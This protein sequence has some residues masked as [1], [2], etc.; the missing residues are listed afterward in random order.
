[1]Y[2]L[3]L[4]PRSWWSSNDLNRVFNLIILGCRRHPVSIFFLKIIGKT[5]NFIASSDLK[6]SITQREKEGEV[7]LSCHVSPDVSWRQPDVVIEIDGD[8]TS[9]SAVKPAHHTLVDRLMKRPT[10]E[11]FINVWSESVKVWPLISSTILL[12]ARL[13]WWLPSVP[14]PLLPLQV[15]AQRIPCYP[16]GVHGHKK[17]F[18]RPM[19]TCSRRPWKSWPP[20]TRK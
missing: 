2:V 12:S 10:V 4:I 6:R 3:R 1:M 20:F 5:L 9:P 17:Y 18:L 13:Y 11:E 7:L 8:V 16:K 19:L 14:I 15:V